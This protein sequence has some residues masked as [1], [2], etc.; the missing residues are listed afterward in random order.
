MTDDVESRPMKWVLAILAAMVISSAPA[1]ANA[2]QSPQSDAALAGRYGAAMQSARWTGPMLASNAETLPKGHFYTEPYFFDVISGGRHNPG[3]SGYYQYGLL[4]G[5]TVGVQPELAL[6]THRA[7]HGMALGDFKLLSQLRLTHF[8]PDHRIP[9]IA[10]VLQEVLPTGK[11]DRLGP[12]EDGHGSGSFATEVGV[13][14]QYYFL[15]KNDRLLRARLNFLERFPHGTD[16]ADRSVYGTGPGF[17]GHAEPG[18]K[19]TLI[20]AIEYSVTK[21]WVLALDV[22][23]ESTRKTTVKGRYAGGPLVKQ[24]FPSSWSVGF[25]PAIEYNWSD[26]SGILLGVWVS[27]KGHNSRASVTPALAYSRFW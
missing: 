13:N 21:E 4:E 25:A 22:I 1:T 18:A 11:H 6:G 23:R 3:T 5:F 2:A 26:R 15:F 16:V 12:L 19:T 27:S 9:T 24:T 14:L 8:T 7:N 17:R 20:G 10:V